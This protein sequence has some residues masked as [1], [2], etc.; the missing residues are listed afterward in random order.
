MGAADVAAGTQ[1]MRSTEKGLVDPTKM[2]M[3]LV[4]T[5]APQKGLFLY[6]YISIY[7]YTYSVYVYIY[8]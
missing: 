7:I 8:K 3:A 2:N 6:L 5:K 4:E 1:A